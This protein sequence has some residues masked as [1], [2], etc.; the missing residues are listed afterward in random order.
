MLQF[1]NMTHGRS[2]R[3]AAGKCSGGGNLIR[4]FTENLYQSL[5]FSSKEAIYII[6]GEMPC[7]CVCVY[8][9]IYRQIQIYSLYSIQ[10]FS[11]FPYLS[12]S[13]T[14]T[15]YVGLQL[16]MPIRKF[17]LNLFYSSTCKILKI[18]SLIQIKTEKSIYFHFNAKANFSI[19]MENKILLKR[20]KSW[21]FCQY[22]AVS[23]SHVP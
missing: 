3:N 23:S 18:L 21:P 4:I 11:E 10:T 19:F 7:M 15:I 16:K 1:K 5:K 22:L 12:L 14:D 2:L 17:S 9:S 20:K 6:Y 8:I 13:H